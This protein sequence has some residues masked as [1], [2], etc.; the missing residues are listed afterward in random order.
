MIHR[1]ATDPDFTPIAAITNHYIRTTAIHFGYEDVTADELRRLWRQHEHRFPWI[2]A[3]TDGEVA[4]YAKAGV[5]RERRAYE[6]TVESGI[7][8]APAHCSRGHGVPLYRRLVDVLRAQGFHTVVGGATM[9]ND[10]SVRLHERLG[11]EHWGTVKQAGYKNDR[12]HDVAFWQL[13]LQPPG[14]AAAARI[15]TPAE[16]FAA[17]A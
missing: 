3:E 9:P 12:W 13:F 14:A 16:A 6:W 4:G 1:L 2:V 7:Y 8:L 10:A 5:Y 15:R 17:T 11:F